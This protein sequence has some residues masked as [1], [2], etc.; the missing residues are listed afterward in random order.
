MLLSLLLEGRGIVGNSSDSLRSMDPNAL[1]IL[2]NSNG[3]R[4]LELFSVDLN[5]VIYESSV[6]LMSGIYFSVVELRILV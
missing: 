6:L 5:Y 3:R 1:S 2:N 4:M